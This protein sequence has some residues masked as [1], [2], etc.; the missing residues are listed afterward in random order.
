MGFVRLSDTEAKR[1]K[2][3][4]ITKDYILNKNALY[5]ID[6]A[7]KRFPMRPYIHVPRG[8][9]S[10]LPHQVNDDNNNLSSIGG[11]TNTNSRDY[12]PTVVKFKKILPKSSGSK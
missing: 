5:E 10:S 3:F 7:G 6:I 2:S 4:V 9:L 1:H 12:K 8:S 11:S